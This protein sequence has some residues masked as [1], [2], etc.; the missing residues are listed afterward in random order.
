MTL[1]GILSLVALLSFIL[2]LIKDSSL[3]AKL[4]KPA[5]ML[6]INWGLFLT[7]VAAAGV[8]VVLYLNLQEQLGT[9][10]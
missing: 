8:V 4:R 5:Y 1:F 7:S 10:L 6:L 3:K 9:K 2:L